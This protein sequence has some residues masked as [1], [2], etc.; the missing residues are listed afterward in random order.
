MRIRFR[1]IDAAFEADKHALVCGVSAGGDES[2]TFERAPE[3]MADDD[4]V[5]LEHK[6]QISGDMGARENVDSAER[7]LKW[8]SRDNLVPWPVSLGSTLSWRWMIPHTRYLVRDCSAFFETRQMYSSSPNNAMASDTIR[9]SPRAP[10]GARHRGR[11]TR[12]RF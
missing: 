5:H 12:E 6:H 10:H 4:G 8:N 2:L 3:C 9:S 11:Y 7:D 1:A